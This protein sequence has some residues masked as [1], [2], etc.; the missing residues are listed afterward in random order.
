MA[1]IYQAITS[2]HCPAQPTRLIKADLMEVL[3]SFHGTLK[4]LL[5][6]VTLQLYPFFPPLLLLLPFRASS[7][8]LMHV[9]FFPMTLK[10]YRRVILPI[11][12]VGTLQ[13][14]VVLNVKMKKAVGTVDLFQSI[15][16]R[17][18]Q[19]LRY[20]RKLGKKSIPISKFGLG[21]CGN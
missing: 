1:N 21:I 11:L 3:C 12:Y 7:S 9:V 2:Q 15:G 20:N 6:Q 16:G 10:I 18:W 14:D 8:Q 17:G 13:W 5:P 4:N 19:T